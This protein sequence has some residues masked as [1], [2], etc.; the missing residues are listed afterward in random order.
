MPVFLE[1][2]L[3]SV[4]MLIIFFIAFFMLFLLALAMAP[5][6]RGLSKVIWDYTTP[7]KPL[8]APSKGNFKEFSKKH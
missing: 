7:K 6:E 8:P 1:A 3:I 5:I 4:G 2:I